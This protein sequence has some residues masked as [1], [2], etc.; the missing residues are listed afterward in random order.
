MNILT[1]L[2]LVISLGANQTQGNIYSNCGIITSI[3]EEIVTVE[4][5]NGNQYQFEGAEDY[6]VMDLVALTMY[7]NGTE[8]IEDDV[9]L[10]A[11]YAGNTEQFQNV[12]LEIVEHEFE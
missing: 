1:L 2:T 12:E 5:C 8:N 10:N 11:K 3:D 6:E 7:D 9:I 4:M